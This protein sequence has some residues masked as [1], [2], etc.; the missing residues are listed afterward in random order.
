MLQMF[1]ETILGKN[2]TMVIS[3]SGPLFKLEYTQDPKDILDLKKKKVEL[4]FL[5]PK[6][7][8][9][10]VLVADFFLHYIESVFR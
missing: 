1:P 2:R 3:P 7:D 6:I 10:S 9:E 4:V 8:L 5:S